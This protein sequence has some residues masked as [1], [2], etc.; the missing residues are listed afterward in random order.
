MKLDFARD[1]GGFHKQLVQIAQ[2]WQNNTGTQWDLKLKFMPGLWLSAV[3]LG[4]D[5]DIAVSDVSIVAMLV[6]SE[7]VIFDLF[8][9][10]F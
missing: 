6:A 2:K 9:E 7:K 3:F 8:Q 4:Q 10:H 1:T 5:R